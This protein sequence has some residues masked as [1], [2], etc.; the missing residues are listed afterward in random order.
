MWIKVLT[1]VATEQ[2]VN[3]DCVESVAPAN[4]E[5]KWNS[6]LTYKNGLQLFVMEDFSFFVNQITS[7]PDI[8]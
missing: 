5:A 6:I 1:H 8:S 3:M 4:R 7:K 2:L